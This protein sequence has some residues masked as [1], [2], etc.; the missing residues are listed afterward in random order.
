M[1]H[2]RYSLNVKYYLDAHVIL[3]S[4]FFNR[5]EVSIKLPL[6]LLMSKKEMIYISSISI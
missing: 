1:I 4:I 2:G 3:I 5:I 6:N